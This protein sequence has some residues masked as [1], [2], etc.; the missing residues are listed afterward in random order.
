MIYFLP[1]FV[2]SAARVRCRKFYDG[3]HINVS[4]LRCAKDYHVWSMFGKVIAK[5]NKFS[6]YDSR[7]AICEMLGYKRGSHNKL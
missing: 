3:I 5:T 6:F 7:T 4:C 1:L 2:T